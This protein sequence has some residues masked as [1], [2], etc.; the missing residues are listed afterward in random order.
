M[1]AVEQPAADGSSADEESGEDF[2]P[3]SSEEV[4]GRQDSDRRWETTRMGRW[5]LAGSGNGALVPDARDTKPL[6]D[7]VDQAVRLQEGSPVADDLRREWLVQAAAVRET[8]QDAIVDLRILLAASGQDGEASATAPEPLSVSEQR[9]IAESFVRDPGADAAAVP[10]LM[11]LLSGF[12]DESF[13]RALVAVIAAGV[14][15]PRIPGWVPEAIREL[16][17][18]RGWRDW[19]SVIWERSVDDGTLREMWPAVARDLK[20]P[21]V[22]PALLSTDD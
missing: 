11:S 5:F 21:T 20:L 18:R 13:D 8:R 19:G 1:A 15:A 6:R 17:V 3:V 14:A 4:S 22:S 10:A 2:E 7:L 12:E 16:V 9:A